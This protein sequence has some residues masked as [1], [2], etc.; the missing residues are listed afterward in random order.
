MS[1]CAKFGVES[2]A[3]SF[4][5]ADFSEEE[6]PTELAAKMEMRVRR[7]S[8]NTDFILDTLKPPRERKASRLGLAI[9]I[10]SL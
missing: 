10:L 7:G 4:C 6:Q 9:R 2:L 5:V 1:A 8:V 3:D